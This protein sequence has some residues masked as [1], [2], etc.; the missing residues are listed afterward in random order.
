MRIGKLA[1]LS[2]LSIDTI[3]FYE[4]RGLINEAHFER[5]PSGYRDYNESALERL[6]LVKGTQAAGFSLSEI[7]ELFDRWENNELND[8]E[9]AARLQEKSAQVARKIAELQQ[10]QQYLEQKLQM[11][12]LSPNPTPSPIPMRQGS[13][14]HP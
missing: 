12:G 7:A 2:G 13:P 11:M 4:K 8:A 5:L 10:V 9:I 6:Q 1:Q 3:R 14:T